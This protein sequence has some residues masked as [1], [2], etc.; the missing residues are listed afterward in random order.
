MKSSLMKFFDAAVELEKIPLNFDYGYQV[1]QLQK[2]VCRL[3]LKKIPF[4]KKFHHIPNFL[5]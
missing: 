3:S 2:I 4:P 1:M 5:K